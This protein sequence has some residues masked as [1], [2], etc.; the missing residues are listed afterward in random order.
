VAISYPWQQGQGFGLSK[1]SFLFTNRRKGNSVK[2]L[3][4]GLSAIFLALSLVVP[5]MADFAPFFSL[6]MDTSW[7]EYGQEETGARADYDTICRDYSDLGRMESKKVYTHLYG[8]LRF[9]GGSLMVGQNYDPYTLTSSQVAPHL[10]YDLANGNE[11][12]AADY[13][14]GYGRLWDT[15][16]NQVKMMLDNGLYVTAIQPEAI[17]T[18]LAAATE[19]DVTLPKMCLGWEVQSEGLYLNPGFAYNTF[20]VSRTGAFDDKD[21]D[22]WLLYVNA[23]LGLGPADLKGS[24]H[25]GQNL[26]NFGLLNREDAAYAQ[27]DGDHIADSNCYGGYVQVAFPIDPTT[28][29][30]GVGYTQSQNQALGPDADKQM[31]CF[32]QAKFP[33]S[34]NFWVVPEFSYYDRM[35]DASKQREPE[36][37]FAGLVWEMGF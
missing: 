23:K 3:A 30:L 15:G 26:G 32:V 11:V 18:G 9:E 17:E 13:F 28:I 36:A 4:I 31:S 33:F 16:Q 25:Y 35:E 2:K 6:T 29:T 20:E 12:G 14:I 27:F 19:A 22:S 34:D 1:T 37:W 24:V 21:L 10:R 7:W 8:T 5:A